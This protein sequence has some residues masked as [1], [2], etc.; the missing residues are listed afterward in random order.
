MHGP[1]KPTLPPAEV[2]WTSPSDVL[3]KRPPPASPSPARTPADDPAAKRKVAAIPRHILITWVWLGALTLSVL[4]LGVAWIGFPKSPPLPPSLPVAKSRAA[5][6]VHAYPFNVYDA[7]PG[8]ISRYPAG[9]DNLGIQGLQWESVSWYRVCCRSNN[10]LQCFPTESVALRKMASGS[11]YLEL[12][13][14]QSLSL[15]GN[16]SWEPLGSVGSRC[17]LYWM[18]GKLTV[19]N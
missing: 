7:T 15:A 19:E 2:T 18:D 10:V 12:R 9:G 1:L 6:K 14:Q 4:L 11:V 5:Q 3:F 17:T 16:G 13:N 8:K